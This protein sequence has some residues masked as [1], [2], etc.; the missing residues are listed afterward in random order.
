MGAITVSPRKPTPIYQMPPRK[1]DL[2]KIVVANESVVT[3][4][5]IGI[6]LIVLAVI[7][8]LIFS[9][10]NLN[11]FTINLESG[12]ALFFG[13]IIPIFMTFVGIILYRIKPKDINLK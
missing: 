3:A 10:W 4:K 5:R 8:H 2:P 6:G 11:S 9:G 1:P 12:V 13:I 7:F